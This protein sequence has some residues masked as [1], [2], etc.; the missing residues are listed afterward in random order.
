M[1]T[2]VLEGG[3]SITLPNHPVSIRLQSGAHAVRLEASASSGPVQVISPT[4]GLMVVPK[5]SEAITIRAVPGGG[6]RFGPG[7]VL[8]LMVGYESRQ[9]L[10]PDRGVLSGV[11]VSGL[12]HRDILVLE[13][14]GDR[15]RVTVLGPPAAEAPLPP[16]AERARDAARELLG[17][18][19][20]PPGEAITSVVAVDLSASMRGLH[21][22]GTVAQVLDIIA[23][24]HRVIGRS[25]DGHLRA[26]LVTDTPR[27]LTPAP[28]E[29]F[30]SAVTEQCTDVALATGF[31]AGAVLDVPGVGPQSDRVRRWIVTDGVPA[32]AASLSGAAGVELICLVPHSV[33]EVGIGQGLSTTV[34]GLPEAAGQ[35]ATFGSD[36]E[37]VRQIVTSLVASF[38]S[39]Q[40]VQA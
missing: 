11:D 17:T 7:S 37:A 13:P 4:A 16:V 29:R 20:L 23:G 3:K 5:V 40:G 25:E 22:D 39:Q 32:D 8:D 26:A 14:E 9:D 12:R 19:Q 38:R 10:D 18:D 15:I 2:Y 6:D 34:I 1:P 21:T 30:A 24:I 31:R 33:A 36:R 27:W 28:P 35:P